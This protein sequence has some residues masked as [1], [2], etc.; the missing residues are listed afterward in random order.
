MAKKDY[1]SPKM[2]EVKLSV[3]QEFLAGSCATY[4]AGGSGCSPDE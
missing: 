1:K 2:E 3:E 4:S